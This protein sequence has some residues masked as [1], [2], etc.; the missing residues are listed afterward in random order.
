[1]TI[2]DVKNSSG[3][4]LRYVRECDVQNFTRAG[5]LWDNINTRCKIGGNY[6]L[7][8]PTYKGC[9][10]NFRDFQGFANWCQ[11]QI[12]YLKRDK[13]LRWWA[14]DKDLLGT[15]LSYDPFSCVFI[16]N[17]INILF[18]SNKKV[19][20][21]D[22]PIG[23]GICHGR[24]KKYRSQIQISGKN[25]QLGNSYTPEAAHRLWQQA[26]IKEINKRISE[27]KNSLDVRVVNKLEEVINKLKAQLKNGEETKNLLGR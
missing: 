4:W 25:T 3:E 16:P 24:N 8:H 21:E 12:G 9:I 6:Q 10:N 27:Y 15:G 13:S 18:K 7:N 19:V 2:V 5:R 23:V 14:I 22:L 26:K 17:D 1:M 11:S 20:Y